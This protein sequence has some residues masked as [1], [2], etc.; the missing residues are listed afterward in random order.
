VEDVYRRLGPEVGGRAPGQHVNRVPVEN[1]GGIAAGGGQDAVVV[2]DDRQVVPRCGRNRP[3]PVFL[4]RHGLDRL[5]VPGAGVADLGDHLG[6]SGV[7]A[8][9]VDQDLHVVEFLRDGGLQGEAEGIRA[10]AG[11]QNDREL[12]HNLPVPR[13]G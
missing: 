12:G 11:G 4:H 10:P 6:R 1:P 13:E 9:F 3:L 2:P 7:V 8:A 5:D